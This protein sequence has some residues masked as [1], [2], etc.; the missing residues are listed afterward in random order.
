MTAPAQKALLL[1]RPL[2]DS[3]L[4]IVARGLKEDVLVD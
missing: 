1:Q 4:Q 3:A 2:T